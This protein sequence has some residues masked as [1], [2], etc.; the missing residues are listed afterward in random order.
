MSVYYELNGKTIILT[1]DQYFDLDDEKIQ[2][3]IADNRGFEV[4]D[5][6]CDINFKEFKKFNVPEVEINDLSEQDIK[7]IENEI[8]RDTEGGDN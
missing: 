7:N 5:P 1:I 2:D 8:K 6:F 4:N 3:L